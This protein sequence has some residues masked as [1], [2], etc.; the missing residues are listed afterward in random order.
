[1]LDMMVRHRSAKLKATQPSSLPCMACWESLASQHLPTVATVA[2]G[3]EMNNATH[4]MVVDVHG[5]F[6]N[7]QL[8]SSCHLRNPNHAQPSPPSEDRT[9]SN[10]LLHRCH[11]TSL[12]VLKLLQAA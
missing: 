10:W 6:V 4:E 5:T 9:A 12:L 2:A 1:M 7:M 8:W 3:N 11:L